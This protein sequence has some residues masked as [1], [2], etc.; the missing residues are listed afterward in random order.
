MR[1][2][3]IG[4]PYWMAPEVIEA[5]DYD[6]KVHIHLIRLLEATEYSFLIRITSS[7]ESQ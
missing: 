1:N 4:T 6:E 2:T 7:G 5:I 3:V